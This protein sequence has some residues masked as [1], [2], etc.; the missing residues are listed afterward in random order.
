M[1]TAFYVI[2]TLS[3]DVIK[4]LNISCKF[5]LT[6]SAVINNKENIV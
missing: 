3:D 6:E 1:V 5:R 4:T 2:H